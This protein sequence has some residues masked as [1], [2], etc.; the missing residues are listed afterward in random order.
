MLVWMA[1]YIGLHAF[2]CLCLG[3]FACGFRGVLPYRPAVK[4]LLGA[5]CAPF[6]IALAVYL[7][8]IAWPGA[9]VLLR[10]AFP[11]LVCAPLALI[12]RGYL[13]LFGFLKA[14]GGLIK[15]GLARV[16]AF[17]AAESVTIR[18]KPLLDKALTALCAALIV[19]LAGVT[20]LKLYGNLKAPFVDYDALHYM[21]QARLYAKDGDTL[22]FSAETPGTEYANAYELDAHGALWPVYLGHALLFS[23]GRQGG[24]LGDAAPRAAVQLCAAYFFFA[25]AALCLLLR[26]DIKTLLFALALFFCVWR[27][28]SAAMIASRDYFRLT[29]LLLLSAY[30]LSVYKRAGEGAPFAT[31]ADGLI[32]A[33]LVFYTIQGHAINV[34]MC[35]VV[36]ALLF[37]CLCIKRAAFTRLLL[38]GGGALAGAL[39]GF[40]KNIAHLIRYGMLRMTTTVLSRGTPFGAT[41]DEINASY[42]RRA[43]AANIFGHG[44]NA[45]CIAAGFAG[46]VYFIVKLIAAR[47]EKRAIGGEERARFALAAMTL[48]LLLPFTGALDIALPVSKDL[49]INYRYSLYIYP[50]FAIVGALALSLGLERAKR[51]GITAAAVACGALALYGVG[52]QWRAISEAEAAGY[53]QSYAGAAGWLA[54]NLPGGRAFSNYEPA[55]YFFDP[56]GTVIFSPASIAL[57][58]NQ[59]DAELEENIRALNLSAAAL[60]DNGRDMSETSLGRYLASR[61]FVQLEGV[62]IYPLAPGAARE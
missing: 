21:T 12:R 5:A 30:A 62:R 40:S 43:D 25:F 49:L 39:A 4:F 6:I 60:F 41:P 33:A 36:L 42:A 27:F 18:V 35:F 8:G 22:A 47:R 16:S 24:Y 14:A 28:G 55:N 38:L 50:Y 32:L 54:V 59:T 34:V 31:A 48:A 51:A 23:P 20:A 44:L 58:Y 56:P 3:C 11:L 53:N 61:P 15:R 19:L 29:A 57:L 26:R 45:L 9:P 2:C 13:H 7:L 46:I 37:V 1:A 17:F 52:T 10:M